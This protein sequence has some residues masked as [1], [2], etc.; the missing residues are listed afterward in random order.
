VLILF[1]VPAI[2][3]GQAPIAV[4]LVGASTI[5]FAT[6]YLSHGV[7]LKT[8][9]ALLGTLGALILTVALGAVFVGGAHLTGLAS[10]EAGLVQLEL[11]AVDLRGLILG[12][13]VI[14]T[15][16]VLDDVTI[17]QA[18]AVAELRRANP[19]LSRIDLYRRAMRI[20][21]DHVAATVNTLVLAYAGAALPV[22]LLFAIAGNALSTAINGE[23]VA[24][25]IIRT[26][27]GSIGLIAAVPMTSAL[28]AWV[29][30]PP[31]AA[32]EAPA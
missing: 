2:L 32:A 24:E 8:S 1:V 5:M 9:T 14:G 7:N 27:V 18:A 22:F 20:G 28:A 19:D 21:R 26:L 6:L 13:I 3:D 25:E 12:G 11:G 29:L 10:E 30:G 16:G 17:A 15:L 31:R 4:A 23:V